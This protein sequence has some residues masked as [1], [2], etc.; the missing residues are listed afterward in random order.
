MK[1][2]HFLA[3]IVMVA[4]IAI[5]QG[6]GSD[7]KDEAAA[8][9]EARLDSIHMADSIQRVAMLDSM[10]NIADS[11]MMEKE[12][13]ETPAVSRTSSS[14]SSA[15]TKSG[16]V[17]TTPAPVKD[18]PV[19]TDQKPKE[20]EPGKKGAESESGDTDFTPGKK[21]EVPP[22]VGDVL[23]KAEDFVPGKKK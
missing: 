20:F 15:S 9:E 8:R 7:N 6:C 21:G 19:A 3:A 1:F 12:K 2:L 11:L 13:L 4:S 17:A 22:A 18:G 10:A 16:G 5:M 23:E 14:S